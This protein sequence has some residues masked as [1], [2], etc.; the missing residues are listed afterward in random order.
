MT[1]WNY[2][3]SDKSTSERDDN[4]K[5]VKFYLPEN[6]HKKPSRAEKEAIIQKKLYPETSII[7]KVAFSENLYVAEYEEA[8][9]IEDVG[10]FTLDQHFKKQGYLSF[11]K[12][13]AIL[14][15]IKRTHAAGVVHLNLDLSAFA[16]HNNKL[17]ITDFRL[18]EIR[19]NLVSTEILS[20]YAPPEI[21]NLPA[22]GK[23]LADPSMDIYALGW[24]LLYILTGK[25]IEYFLGSFL[26][27]QGLIQVGEKNSL[28]R[29]KLEY[30]YQNQNRYSEVLNAIKSHLESKY[31]ATGKMWS[32]LIVDMLSFDPNQRPLISDVEEAL[33]FIEKNAAM[34]DLDERNSKFNLLFD[35]QK[36]SRKIEQE[37]AR[38]TQRHKDTQSKYK[39]NQPFQQVGTLLK[40]KKNELLSSGI[41]APEGKEEID[42]PKKSAE[43][44]RAE[45][46]SQLGT[47][48]SQTKNYIQSD[49]IL[50]N[51]W[52]FLRG[53]FGGRAK[54]CENVGKIAGEV[55]M[56]TSS[57]FFKTKVPANQV[58]LNNTV[59][60]V[61]LVYKN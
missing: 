42:A 48:Y 36:A 22:G 38:Y 28:E 12:L 17:K 53:L 33:F 47:F 21:V 35:I 2:F 45:I 46:N 40:T 27:D 10:D 44:Y 52:N 14:K 29:W 61:R 49:N 18:S 4:H 20:K 5:I 39:K 58:D 43:Q 11:D 50:V 19:G 13:K 7:G 16:I 1:S 32:R 57:A 9:M 56:M 23:L 51:L 41:A 25:Q 59:E 15:E 54:S 31:E 34:N 60:Q 3:D 30:V 37:K 8:M 26:Y 55:G 24:N 6:D